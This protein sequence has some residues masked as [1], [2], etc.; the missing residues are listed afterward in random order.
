MSIFNYKT[1]VD[2]LSSVNSGIADS[3]Q[4]EIST[5]NSSLMDAFHNQ[6]HV[7]RWQVSSSDAWIPSQSYFRLNI[8]LRK[9]ALDAALDNQ[10]NLARYPVAGLYNSIQF[11]INGHVVCESDDKLQ[12]IEIL[13]DRLHRNKTQKSVIEG[14][15]QRTGVTIDAGA[16]DTA[17][18][19]R[20]RPS[21]EE[22]ADANGVDLIWR[23]SLPI[24]HQ[25]TALPCGEYEL[26]L[27]H[28][29]KDECVR[30]IVE[31]DSTAGV[32][33]NAISLD[34]QKH[35]FNYTT[36]SGR[37]FD[38]GSVLIDMENIKCQQ[39]ST[40]A[41]GSINPRFTV[42]PNTQALSVAF[43]DKRRGGLTDICQP[44][45]RFL[46]YPDAVGA[47]P[48]A[49]GLRRRDLAS[50][51]TTPLAGIKSFQIR[52]AGNLYPNKA[53]ELDS[54]ATSCRGW[55]HAYMD[56]LLQ[57]GQYHDTVPSEDFEEWLGDAGPIFLYQTSK[58]GYDRSTEVVLNLQNNAAAA[59]NAHMAL[60]LFSHYKS[61]A[62]VT[63]VDGKVVNVEK[64]DM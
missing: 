34:V 48:A 13:H 45:S 6:Q 16:D 26:I 36:V 4:F 56:Y 23:P 7:F 51:S 15:A 25:S 42:E 8:R 55:K 24:F 44:P 64:Q 49:N 21:N 38:N 1:S 32:D 3:K 29:S 52:Y 57:T 46:P 59:D 28:K 58:D 33:C 14:N 40:L 5:V 35:T 41:V 47:N 63:V 62:R 17:K 11:K 9:T 12:L 61:V 22:L 39:E 30:C 2:Q 54:T 18:S 53:I 50:F 31:Q 20:G 27:K 10:Q 19:M 60:L 43:I 37:R